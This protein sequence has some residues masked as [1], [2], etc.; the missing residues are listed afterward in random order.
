MRRITL[1]AVLVTLIAV[2]G[3]A[4]VALADGP[5]RDV[6]TFTDTFHDDFLSEAC[7]VDVTTTATGRFMRMTFDGNGVQVVNTISV[8]LVA[9]AGDNVFRFRDVGADV[10]QDANGTLTVLI[11]GQIPFGW[12]GVLKF[13]D[14]TGE[15]VHEPHHWLDTTAVCAALTA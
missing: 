5:E 7:G 2:L 1:F 15:V 13:D 10:L 9:R 11:I 12:T 14:A 3:A 6:E 8:S 4:P